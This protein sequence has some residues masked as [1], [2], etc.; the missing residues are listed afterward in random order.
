MYPWAPS[1]EMRWLNPTLVTAEQRSPL[2]CR[3]E[4]CNFFTRDT[5]G[6][7]V[8]E[9]YWDAPMWTF[10]PIGHEF[11]T[12]IPS[13]TKDDPHLRIAVPRTYQ[14]DSTGYRL[15]TWLVVDETGVWRGKTTWTDVVDG[16]DRPT[17]VEFDLEL[18]PR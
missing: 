10:G 14:Q 1:Y 4:L 7:V 11:E 16:H 3:P 13:T 6:W 9:S 18:L 17:S 8:Q 5:I 12:S 2:E 15:P